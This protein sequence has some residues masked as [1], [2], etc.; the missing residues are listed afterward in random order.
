MQ[1]VSQKRFSYGV[2]FFDQAGTFSNSYVLLSAAAETFQRLTAYSL[3]PDKSSSDQNS[4][5][6]ENWVC[7]I[8]L[9]VLVREL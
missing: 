1:S 3:L 2:A 5:N 8:S 4:Q 9:L 7:A 6:V